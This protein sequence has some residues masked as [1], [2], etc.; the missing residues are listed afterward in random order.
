VD[1]LIE[2]AL[3]E[4][5]GSGDATS[6]SVIAEEDRCAAILVSRGDYVLAGT[7]VAAKVFHTV[8]ASIDVKLQRLDGE[9]VGEGDVILSVA[10]PARSILTAERNALNFLQRMTGI[11]TLVRV[12]VERVAGTGAAILDTRKTTPLH[13]ALEKYA[14]TCGG[15]ENHRMGLYD[16]IMLKDNHLAQWRKHNDGSLEDM[17]HAAR[18]ACPELDIEVEVESVEDFQKV[19]AAKPEWI[20]LDNMSP[21][22]MRECVA[23]SG[24]LIRLEASGGITLETIL[25]VAETGVDAIS[26]G[27]LT[28]SATWA[29]LALEFQ[30][31]DP[32]V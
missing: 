30:E 15:G 17:V 31:Q 16:R 3:S 25:E 28:H 5:V 20:L 9:R 4:D 8:D 12:Y 32:D 11:A 23:L 19:A 22:Q 6:R 2:A 7:T 24:E 1:A 10:G 21:D 13:R 27:A 14:V 29:D 26:V 18:K